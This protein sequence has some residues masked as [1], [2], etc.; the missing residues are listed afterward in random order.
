MA[1]LRK[2]DYDMYIQADNLSQIVNAN[3]SLRIQ[4]ELAAQAELISYLVQKYDVAQ[5]FSDTLVWLPSISYKATNLVNLD[6]PAYVP[7]TAYVTTNLTTYNGQCFICTG[8]TTG[9]FDPAKWTLLGN[10]YDLFFVT[11]PQPLFNYKACYLIGNQVFWKDKVYT[12]KLP[13]SGIFPD[14]PVNG[15]TNWGNGVAYSVSAGTLPTDTTKWTF[16]DNRNQQL[17]MHMIDI[18]I[19]HL[20]SRINPRNIPQLRIDRYDSAIAWLKDAGRGDYITADIP[21]LQP[22]SGVRVRWGS[23]IKNVNTY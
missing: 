14:D 6:Y 7:A 11:L 21:L 2:K 8:S 22:D 4:V 12:A 5:E 16:G 9:T 18:V 23:N 17:V 1:Y 10:Q 15:F 19:Y 13:V 20:N 3:D